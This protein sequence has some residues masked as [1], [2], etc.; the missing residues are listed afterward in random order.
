MYQKNTIVVSSYTYES[1]DGRACDIFSQNVLIDDEY[2][3]CGYVVLCI[4]NKTICNE[5]EWDYID[6]LWSYWL[7]GLSNLINGENTKGSFPDQTLQWSFKHI[8]SKKLNI[9]IGKK[10]IDIDKK[11]FLLA[12]TKHA[13]SFFKRVQSLTHARYNYDSDIRKAKS[14]LEVLE[15]K[16]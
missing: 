13:L 1:K 14:I 6:V 3:I 8:N 11:E 10:E 16:N 5:E 2:A 4:K 9:S 7:D 12:M 15:C